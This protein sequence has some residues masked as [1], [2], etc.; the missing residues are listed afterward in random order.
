MRS[1]IK[2]LLP[3]KIVEERIFLIRGQKV[4]IDKDLAELYNV[5]T[6]YLN[7]QV[8]RNIQRFPPEFM[9]QL[10]RNGKNEL[11]TIWHRFES[12]KHSVVRP[13]A[14]TEHGVAML[15]S[16]L[17]SER[18]IKINILIIKAFV[19]F[20]EVLSTHEGL[21]RKL[22]D[23]EKRYAAHDERIQQIFSYIKKLVA[24]HARHR[25]QIGFAPPC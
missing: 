7:R 14:F 21:V 24:P 5:E 15:S 3:Q 18:A 20:R 19:K 23:L 4:M 11:V 22:E 2:I 25:R 6:K 1:K 8:K 16:V 13:Y 17:R 9:F 12:L 10:S